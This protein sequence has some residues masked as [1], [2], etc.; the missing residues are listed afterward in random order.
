MKDYIRRFK[1]RAFWKRLARR[2][3]WWRK[4][5][6]MRFICETRYAYLPK[7]R[8]HIIPVLYKRGQGPVVKG[9]FK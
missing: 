2:I 3:F 7:Y 6:Q 8:I 9:K 5:D 1:W 4:K